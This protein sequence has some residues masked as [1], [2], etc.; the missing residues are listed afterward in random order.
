[1]VYRLEQQGVQA[2]EVAGYQK[3]QDLSSAV[4]QNE[5]ATGRAVSDHESGAWRIPF[6]EDVD[7]APEALLPRTQRLEHADVVVRERCKF[8]KLNYERALTAPGIVAH[9]VL[10]PE[11]YAATTL[12][13]DPS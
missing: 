7:T 8:Q 6:D 11:A 12:K 10:L 1:M 13:L 3:S 4:H 5:V 9:F 2:D